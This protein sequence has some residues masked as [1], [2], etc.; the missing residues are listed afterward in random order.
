MHADAMPDAD[1]STL[2]RP[3][4][5]AARMVSIIQRA[6]TLSPGARLVANPE[7]AA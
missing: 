1:V 5:I 6:H 2:A 4:D 3:E 7:V